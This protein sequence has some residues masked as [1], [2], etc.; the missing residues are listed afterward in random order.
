MATLQ[1]RAFS[2]PVCHCLERD[3][4]PYTSR[5]AIPY[6][7]RSARCYADVTCIN[8]W[9]RAEREEYVSQT[10]VDG[11]PSYTSRS[12]RCYADVTCVNAWPRAERE[13]YDV[14]ELRYFAGRLER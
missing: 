14:G 9:P 5:S 13:E 2:L 4:F 1:F 12:A 3:G 8:A 6:T 10:R 7:S 11:K